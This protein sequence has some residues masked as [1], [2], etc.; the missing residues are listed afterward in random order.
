M[1]KQQRVNKLIDNA[2]KLG[3]GSENFEQQLF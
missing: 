3:T 1:K 2:L